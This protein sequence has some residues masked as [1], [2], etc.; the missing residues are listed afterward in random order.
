MLNSIMR[1]FEII[2][3]DGDLTKPQPPKPPKA[4]RM[5]PKPPKADEHKPKEPEAGI[6]KLLGIEAVT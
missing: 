2:A 5:K 4:P 1:Y 3:E 6:R